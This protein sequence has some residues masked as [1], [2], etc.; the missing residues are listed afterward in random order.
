MHLSSNSSHRQRLIVAVALLL[1]LIPC[2]V[3][4]PSV[5]VAVLFAMLCI[6]AT[7]E[8]SRLLFAVSR[9]FINPLWYAW[10]CLTSVLL[11]AP[12]AIYFQHQSILYIAALWW[13]V[14]LVITTFYTTRL[15]ANAAFRYFLA[16]HN[17]VALAACLVA[18]YRLHAMAWPWLLYA[19]ALVA[20]S[21][22]A[23]YY[24]G[25]RVGKHQL[26][27]AISPGKSREGLLAAL[28]ASLVLSASVAWLFLD[29]ATALQKLSL[30]LLSLIACIAGVVGDL[31]ESM[32]KRCA[33]VK[34]SGSLLAAHGG[35]LDRLDAFLA[36]AP[37]IALGLLH[38]Y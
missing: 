8:W 14:A 5:G 17:V 20:L 3:W 38:L 30:I 2:I 26:A 24:V 31:T 37:V 13:F 36:A 22:S 12:L 11:I 28:A 27:A 18:V 29:S 4:L 25:Q 19:L 7:Y 6:P 35:V 21:D 16:L 33:G 34:E 15:C 9:S 32:A 1:V 23:A 10:L